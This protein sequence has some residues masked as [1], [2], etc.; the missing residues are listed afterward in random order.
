MMCIDI[1]EKHAVITKRVDEHDLLMSV[2]NGDFLDENDRP[3]K[4]FF[5]LVKEYEARW[6]VAS[7][8]TTLPDVPDYDA[9]DHLLR[10]INY[11]VVM[12]GSQL[13]WF[14]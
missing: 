3:T 14:Q 7:K 11:S 9:I 4:E 6:D 8:N 5:E 12:R 2:R 10:D 13:E 1:L